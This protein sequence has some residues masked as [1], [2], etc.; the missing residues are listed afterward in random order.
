MSEHL[1]VSCPEWSELSSC[2]VAIT[3]LSWFILLH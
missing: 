1:S 2:F 3:V